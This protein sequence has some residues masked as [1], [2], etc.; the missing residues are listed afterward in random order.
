[1]PLM[2]LRVSV[3]Q[4]RTGGGNKVANL[5][6]AGRLERVKPIFPRGKTSKGAVKRDLSLLAASPGTDGFERS[7]RGEG[8]SPEEDETQESTL[9]R[10]P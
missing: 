8:E 1:M 3:L 9:P 4:K 7:T 10:S 2:G 5:R 6:R